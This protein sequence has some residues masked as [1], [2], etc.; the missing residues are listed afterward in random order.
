MLIIQKQGL[1]QI[2]FLVFF[3]NNNLTKA[4][5]IVT[6]FTIISSV[7]RT[8]GAGPYISMRAEGA[9]IH[10]H[11]LIKEKQQQRQHVNNTKI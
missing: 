11:D 1:V 2:R 10:A 9:R 7:S 4:N 8:Q 5:F 6:G 3:N